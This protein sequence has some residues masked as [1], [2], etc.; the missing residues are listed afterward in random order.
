MSKPLSDA[1]SGV[2]DIRS[3]RIRKKKGVDEEVQC[4]KPT[5]RDD[6]AQAGSKSNVSVCICYWYAHDVG[7][8]NTRVLYTR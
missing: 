5:L 3:Q 4:D 6:S 7:T 1:S 2:L 8:N